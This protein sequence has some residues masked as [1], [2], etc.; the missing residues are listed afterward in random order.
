M[1]EYL[2]GQYCATNDEDSIESGIKTVKEILS[3]HYVHRNE[4]GLIRSTIREKG[5]YKII[6]KVSV[7]LNDKKD[8]YE[9]EFANLGIKEGSNRL[10]HRQATP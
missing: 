10:G 3:K 4:A 5:F 9:T 2:L 8:C 1:L 6:D 7:S